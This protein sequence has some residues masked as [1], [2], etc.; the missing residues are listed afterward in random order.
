[1]EKYSKNLEE[2]VDE[3]TDQL[4]EEKRRTDELLH[5]MLPE[6]VHGPPARRRRRDVIAVTS[7]RRDVIVVVIA[8]WS[9]TDILCFTCFLCVTWQNWH[10]CELFRNTILFCNNCYAG[11]AV[12]VNHWYVCLSVCLSVCLIFSN[13]SSAT[14]AA[15]LQRH[16][17][18]NTPTAW[19]CPVPDNRGRKDRTSPS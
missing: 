4:R 18:A 11:V 3:R 12:S 5:Q 6:W 7:R 17:L 14:A 16:A 13:V 15:S 9:Q 8:V 19:Y 10:M 2:I 1:M